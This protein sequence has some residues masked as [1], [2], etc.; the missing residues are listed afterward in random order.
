MTK[1]SEI[2]PGAFKALLTG[3]GVLGPYDYAHFP[4]SDVPELSLRGDKPFTLFTSVCFKNV[5]GGAILEQ[6]NS[7]CLGV[8]DGELYVAAKKSIIFRLI[9]LQPL[10]SAQIRQMLD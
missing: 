10:Y 7:F 1:E 8:M 5:Q 4:A 6:E 2:R 3:Y 9:F